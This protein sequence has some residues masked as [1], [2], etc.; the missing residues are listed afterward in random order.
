MKNIIPFIMT[1]KL[2][3]INASIL[4]LLLETVPREMVSKLI[5]NLQPNNN[6]S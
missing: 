1:N 6:L 2:T 3:Q 4:E 5:F